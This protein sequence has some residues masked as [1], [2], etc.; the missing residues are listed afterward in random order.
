VVLVHQVGECSKFFVSLS[1]FLAL[2]AR[3]GV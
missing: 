2:L 3:V 1:R